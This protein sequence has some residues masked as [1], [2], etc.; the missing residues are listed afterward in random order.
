M[1]MSGLVL[2]GPDGRI[3]DK[4]VKP[5]ELMDKLSAAMEALAPAE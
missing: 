5:E 2:V 1:M 3:I 4:L